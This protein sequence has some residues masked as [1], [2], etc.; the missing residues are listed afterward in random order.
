MTPFTVTLALS[1]SNV[2]LN[3]GAGNLVSGSKE[4]QCAAF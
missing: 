4:R 1:L 2:A 3:V